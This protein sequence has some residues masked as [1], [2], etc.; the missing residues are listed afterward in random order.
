[1]TIRVRHL[2]ALCVAFAALVLPAAAQADPDSVVRDCA[3]DG[4]VDQKHSDADKRAA[5]D[6]LPA[7]LDEYS[8]CRAVIGASIGGSP[9]A[10]ASGNH[11]G[12]H[13]AGATAATKAARAKKRKAQA[14]RRAKKRKTTELAL[15]SRKID[16]RNPDVFEASDTSNGLSTPVLLALIAL[17]LLG[18]AALTMAL[19]RRNQGL[20]A[21]LRRVPLPFTRR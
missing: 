12:A 3:A 16:P 8:D 18:A 5:L 21:M 14:E 6:R 11:R 17:G 13:E 19:A 4:S 10:G 9:K 7:D 2:V 15:G 1:M 20:A